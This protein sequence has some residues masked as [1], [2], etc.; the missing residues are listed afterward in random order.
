MCMSLNFFVCYSIVDLMDGKPYGFQSCVCRGPV[1]WV[2]SLIQGAEFEVQPFFPKE[3]AG[4][5]LSIVCHYA[6]SGV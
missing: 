5:S 2:E 1:P 6:K 4:N 3:E